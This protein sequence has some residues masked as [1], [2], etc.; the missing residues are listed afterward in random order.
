MKI[1][2][3]VSNE[4]IA[5]SIKAQY[6]KN[7]KGM[8]TTKNVY[9]FNAIIKEIQ[10]DKT[11]DVVV[12]SEDLEPFTNNNYDVIDNFLISKLVDIRE[13]S[14]KID[15]TNIPI[16]FITT[17]RH[18]Y[19]DKLIKKLYDIAIYNALIGADRNLK[20]ICELIAKPRNQ[21][22]AKK[23]YKILENAGPQLSEDD[24]K[25]VEIKNIIAHYKKLGKNEEMY[26]ESFDNIASQYTDAQL[27]VIIKFLPLNVKAVLE[28]KSRKYQEIMIYNK[29]VKKTVDKPVVASVEK[30][31]S[32]KE[33][34]VELKVETN[35]VMEQISKVKEDTPII[36]PNELDTNKVK[37]LS[38]IELDDDEDLFGINMAEEPVQAIE[39]LDEI[40][41][42]EEIL[43]QQEEAP[44]K[45]RGRPKK[46]K[47][48]P[49][50][51]NEVKRGRGRPKKNVEPE[52][53]PVQVDE[54]KELDLE[55]LTENIPQ[56]VVEQDEATEV[57]LFALHEDPEVEEI[58]E[59]E[60]IVEDVF[61]DELPSMT[62][63]LLE[64]EPVTLN[65]DES[66]YNE[67]SFESSI[68]PVISDNN[69]KAEN[70][71]NLISSDKKI[72]SF[73]GTSKNGTSFIV[74][75]MAQLLSN[76]NIDTAI[77]DMTTNKNS[78]YIYTNNDEALRQTANGSIEKLKNGIAEGLKISKNLTVYTALPNEESSFPEADLIL[79][80]LIQNH[81]LVLIDCD[82]NTPLGYFDN[83]Q[84]IYLV[85]SMD[86]LTI[87]P[88]TAFLR[89][90][91]SKDILKEEKIRVIVNKAAK[92]RGLNEKVIVGGLAYYNDPGMSYMTELFNKDT[93]KTCVIPFDLQ[94]YEKYLGTMVDC[95]LSLSGYS[96]SFM[97]ALNN[98]G[99]MIYPL[100]S[101][102]KSS[103]GKYN[104]PSMNNYGTPFSN[105]IDSTLNKM[106]N[107]Y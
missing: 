23:Y 94:V 105:N 60:P 86:I 71:Q 4:S 9:Y 82:Y 33:K 52:I 72:V 22:E 55:N 56:E 6:Q 8:L 90:L 24:V 65:K 78:Y 81:S 62:D 97:Q 40:E 46:V 2:F 92:V 31:N 77:L 34:E 14:K 80:T 10:N 53:V 18:V 43:P 7:Y 30:E 3:A 102:T 37:K 21:E 68:K 67:P 64:D 36:V 84:E 63:S 106:K 87:Q 19:G 35:R 27:R 74:N 98:L 101:N 93:V 103:K 66:E 107:N 44:K 50:A 70:I 51:S 75:N 13:E 26:V 54:E 1:L 38:E 16:I 15:G 83:S 89:D 79:K 39:S 91:K 20:N 59:N 41:L 12:I 61:E 11:Y 99:S 45:K 88:L 17:D 32:L 73:I 5:N 48:E 85:Q 47:P 100:L 57:N 28:E 25:E 76:M 104:P 95:Q 42:A 58:N 96:K 49:V 69:Y 29:G